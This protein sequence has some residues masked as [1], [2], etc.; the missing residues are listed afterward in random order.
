[1][2]SLEDIIRA[3]RT[4]FDH[5]EPSAGHE[6]R[7]LFKLSH[8]QPGKRTF[9]VSF[10]LKVAVILL[11][12]CLSSLWI[13]EKISQVHSGSRQYALGQV[14]PEYREVEIY[15]TSLINTRVEQLNKFDF[16]EDSTAKAML[17]KELVV[18]DAVYD[19]LQN[20]LKKYPS[21]QRII[22]AMITHYEMKVEVLN[23]ILDQ[24]KTIKSVNPANNTDHENTK[25]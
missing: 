17:I 3:N 9:R 24:L 5:E 8:R 1:M 12:V 25:I 15:F 14:S 23:R 22:D 11:L 2:K 21:D 13:Y 20:E 4:A 18:M 6:D 19:S 10:I 7:F 16:S